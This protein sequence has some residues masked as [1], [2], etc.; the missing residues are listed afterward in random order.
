[1]SE[2]NWEQLIKEHRD[3]RLSQAEFCRRKKISLSTFQYRRY[4]RLQVS[5]P[6]GGSFVRVDGGEK[7]EVEVGGVLLR[8]SVR[9]LPLVIKAL[10]R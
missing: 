9:E 1:M 4:K 2:V 6:S 5:E 8:V 7:V 10:I 3:S